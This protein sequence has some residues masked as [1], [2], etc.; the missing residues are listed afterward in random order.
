MTIKFL[1]P[2]RT[3]NRHLRGLQDEYMDRIG[4][5]ASCRLVETREAGGMP[6]S[7]KARIL[8]VEARG[9]EKHLANDYIICLFD[10]GKEMTSEEL[11]RFLERHGSA[12]RPLTFICGGFLGLA[13]RV[14]DRA[15]TR[16]SL[17]RLTFSHELARVVLLEQVYRGLT[18]LK[19]KHYAK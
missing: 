6:E 19:G 5:L 18:I 13:E 12:S 11:A 8:D 17:S 15:K 10:Q 7:E 16:L 4:R 1:W 2:G 9:L 3:R 14:I